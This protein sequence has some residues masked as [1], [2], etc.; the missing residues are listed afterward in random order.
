VNFT[1]AG[2]EKLGH[3]VEH[4]LRRVLSSP[5]NLQSALSDNKT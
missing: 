2:A 1:K 4:E 5:V 3:Y